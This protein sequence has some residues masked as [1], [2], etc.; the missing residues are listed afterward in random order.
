[1]DEESDA[2]QGQE[3]ATGN[4]SVPPTQTITTDVLVRPKSAPPGAS[5]RRE[6]RKGALQKEVDTSC[7][8]KAAKPIYR[9]QHHTRKAFTHLNQ[10]RR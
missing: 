4:A 9:H 2:A 5:I 10:I 8:I 6:F 1:M 3:T 7:P